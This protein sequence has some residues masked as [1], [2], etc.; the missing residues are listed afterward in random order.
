LLTRKHDR[1]LAGRDTQQGCACPYVKYIATR[2]YGYGGTMIQ[3]RPRIYH[4]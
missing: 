2:T 3:R 1:L 4:A